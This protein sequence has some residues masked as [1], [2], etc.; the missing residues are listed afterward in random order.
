MDS[1]QLAATL[2]AP[3]V[4]VLGVWAVNRQQFGRLLEKVEQ[5]E[6]DIDELKRTFEKHDEVCDAAH[7]DHREKLGDHGERLARLEGAR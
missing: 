5:T 6:K 7:G 2:A 1:L 3:L 4:T